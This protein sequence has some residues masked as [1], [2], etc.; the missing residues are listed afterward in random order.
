METSRAC[1]KCK[2]T[3]KCSYDDTR[4]CIWCDA[5]GSM[6]APDLFAIVILIKGR[7]GLRANRPK[8]GR[9]R[10]SKRAYYVWRLAR[11]HGGADMRMPIMADLD[12]GGDPYK[13]ELDQ[14]SDLVAKWAYGT[15]LAAAHRWGRALGYFG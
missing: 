6:E 7:K 13:T 4:S 2:G 15:D 10:L 8:D 11:F 14:L 5:K 9:D 12:I 3:G 1:T